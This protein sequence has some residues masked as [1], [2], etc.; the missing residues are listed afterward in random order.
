[1]KLKI[2]KFSIKKAKEAVKNS[3]KIEGYKETKNKNIK[4]K[5][6]KIASILC[7]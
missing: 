4:I 1:M 6:N 2:K 5:A 7:P 3:S